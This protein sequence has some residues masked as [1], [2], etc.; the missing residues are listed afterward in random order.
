MLFYQNNKRRWIT[1]P[2]FLLLPFWCTSIYHHSVNLLKVLVCLHYGVKIEERLIIYCRRSCIN[3]VF[4]LCWVSIMNHFFITVSICC[5]NTLIVKLYAQIT[6]EVN[7]CVQN[8]LLCVQTGIE[9]CNS[10]IELKQHWDPF[11]YVIFNGGNGGAEL[12]FVNQNFIVSRCF[13]LWCYKL[14]FSSQSYLG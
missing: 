7:K 2:R 6:S 10:Q 4:L 12:D 3:I 1:T 9:I 8:E 11:N 5:A 14:V 13:R